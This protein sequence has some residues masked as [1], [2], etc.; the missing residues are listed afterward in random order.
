MPEV[1]DV[2]QGT[3]DMLILKALSLE[4]MH[5]WGISDRI[6]QMSRDV[7]RIGQGSLYPALHRFDNRGWVTSYWQTTGNNRI[8]RYYELT[9]AGRRALHE[10][11]DRWRLYT[12]A[13]D[14]VISAE[15]RQS[16]S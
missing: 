10:E 8:A 4:P 7:F 9:A 5:G 11:V 12:S 14:H 13:V 1:V 16:I 6:R 3:L 15:Q 2:M